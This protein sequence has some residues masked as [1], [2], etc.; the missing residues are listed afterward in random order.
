MSVLIPAGGVHRDPELYANP[1]EID[2]EH[3]SVEVGFGDGA[4]NCVGARFGELQSHIALAL[5]IKNYRL[6][7]ASPT[8]Q[9]LRR[10]SKIL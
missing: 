3:F 9:E 6:S 4:R 8:P 1:I 2:P 10:T 5:L 7:L